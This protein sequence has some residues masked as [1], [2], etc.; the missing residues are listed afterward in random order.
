[1]K[2]SRVWI[3]VEKKL[4]EYEVQVLCYYTPQHPF[5]NGKMIGI[6]RRYDL[7]DM[8]KFVSRARFDENGFG[9]ASKVTHWM[10]LPDEP[11]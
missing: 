3:S 6:L 8:N 2:D 11:K 9:M 10:P 4:P 7:T 5:I 1:M